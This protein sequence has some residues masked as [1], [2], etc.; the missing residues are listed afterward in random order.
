M[1]VTHSLWASLAVSP[2][3]QKQSFIVSLDASP[4]LL[5]YEMLCVVRS[6]AVCRQQ[7]PFLLLHF[8]LSSPNKLCYPCKISKLAID[9][10]RFQFWSL[11]FLFLIFII[12]FFSSYIIQSQS[13]MYFFF[14]CNAHFFIFFLFEFFY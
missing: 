8:L 6:I 12:G 2:I 11:F 5:P 3:D 1:E 4:R 7:I 14:Q 9:L 13:V 10:L